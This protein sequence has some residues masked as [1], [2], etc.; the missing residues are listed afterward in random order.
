MFFLAGKNIL[1]QID[2]EC[3]IRLQRN[4]RH[5]MNYAAAAYAN[6]TEKSVM[7]N[8]Q[9]PLI[10]QGPVGICLLV[11]CLTSKQHA[12]ISQRRICPDNF[13]CCHTKIE[14]AD[15]TFHLTQ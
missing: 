11:G 15:Q 2:L 10:L 5:T 3:A 13:M 12:S 7:S 9:M 4:N 8:W 14:V 6:H 1:C